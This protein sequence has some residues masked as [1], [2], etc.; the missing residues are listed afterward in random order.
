[1]FMHGK[2]N[3]QSGGI[4]VFKLERRNGAVELVDSYGEKVEF[5]DADEAFLYPVESLLTAK[6][7]AYL[8]EWVKAHK[9]ELN[10]TYIE[11]MEYIIGKDGG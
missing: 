11:S 2:V 10:K 4:A 3:S 9:G 6:N 1:M 8:R 7:R 5:K